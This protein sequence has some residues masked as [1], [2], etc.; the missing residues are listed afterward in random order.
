MTG[1]TLSAKEKEE[2]KAE[3]DKAN[4]EKFD[5]EFLQGIRLKELEKNDPSRLADICSAAYE[6]GKATVRAKHKTAVN[7][8]PEELQ[9]QKEFQDK[10]DVS[11][12]EEQEI[13]A[14]MND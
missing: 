9:K 3:L 8:S 7:R 5:E 10:W 14:V 4:F 13:K 11:E 1:R 2:V 12:Q 6:L